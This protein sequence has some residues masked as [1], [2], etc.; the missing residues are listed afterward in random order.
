MNI[1][2]FTSKRIYAYV[3]PVRT[4]LDI[5]DP[6]F[7]E[8]KTR[9]VQQG[10]KLKDLV[11]SYIEAGLRGPAVLPQEAFPGGKRAGLPVAIPFESGKVSH[12]AMTNAQLHEIMDAEDLAE[13]RRVT[14]TSSRSE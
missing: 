2:I 11:A 14:Q 10:V 8:V 4:T 1:S 9:A 5:P 3:I 7:K 13:Y 12:L 6:L